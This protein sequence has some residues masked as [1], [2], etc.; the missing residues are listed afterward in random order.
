MVRTMMVCPVE[1]KGSYTNDQKYGDE[2]SLTA[3]NNIGLYLWSQL[4][5]KGPR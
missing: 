1:L 4:P 2:I 5:E 3:A